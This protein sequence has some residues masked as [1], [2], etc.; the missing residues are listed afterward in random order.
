MLPFLLILFIF[1]PGQVRGQ[2]TESLR[3]LQS[4]VLHDDLKE[5]SG[6]I[7][8]DGD[9]WTH[10]DSRDN[11]LFR[12]DPQNG[13]IKDRIPLGNS[14]NTDWE[15]IA[16]DED[17]LYIGD[18][19]NNSGN[20]KDLHILRVKKSSLQKNNP[21]I[22]KI[23]FIFE[24]Q[25]DFTPRPQATD[26]DCEAMI[27]HKGNIYLFTKEWI[28]AGTTLYKLPASPGHHTARMIN[29]YPLTGLI[30]GADIS[31]DGNTIFLSGYTTVIHP[32]IYLL[33]DLGGAEGRKHQIGLPYHQVE[34]IAI[35]N[36]KEI[37]I[38]NEY[39][40][41]ASWIQV[42]QQIHKLELH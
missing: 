14:V 10:N 31:A 36:T 29:S 11:T 17:Y 22:E 18:I 20:R 40:S 2:E 23:H 37:Y 9:L 39:F 12:I 15:D 13:E 8:W 35:K 16:Q 1:L 7:F 5:S 21:E 19:G 42:P 24:D 6:L 33:P 28:T 38:S 26:F 3:P 34:G 4:F 25:N 32:F 30:T 27:V 41:F